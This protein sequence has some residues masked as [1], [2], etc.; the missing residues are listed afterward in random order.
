MA[1]TGNYSIGIENGAQ[2]GITAIY[3]QEL[4]QDVNLF[5]CQSVV[6][7]YDKLFNVL[8]FELPHADTGRNG[9]PDLIFQRENITVA[10]NAAGSADIA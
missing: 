6:K 2:Y 10:S 5:T 8:D 1:E 4:I 7:F 9:F 3:R